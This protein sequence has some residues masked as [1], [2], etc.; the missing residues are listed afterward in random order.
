MCTVTFR[1]LKDNPKS[2]L[3]ILRWITRSAEIIKISTLQIQ[4]ELFI[5]VLYSTPEQ[6]KSGSAC[7]MTRSAND[8]R[9]SVVI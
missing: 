5:Q 7:H 1:T 3:H 4:I 8:R 9:H 6:S 2:S